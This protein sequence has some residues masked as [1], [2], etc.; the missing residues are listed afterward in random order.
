[1]PARFWQNLPLSR[2][3]F[4]HSAS[5]A[6]QRLAISPN[7]DGKNLSVVLRLSPWKQRIMRR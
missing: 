7:F 3:C 6:E 2:I 4:K 5:A 1:M